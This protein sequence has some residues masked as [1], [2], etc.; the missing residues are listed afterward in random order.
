MGYLR[1]S[2]PGISFE[3]VKVGE[4]WAAT[5]LRAGG[6]SGSKP[7]QYVQVSVGGV[8]LD[9]YLEAARQI[10]EGPELADKD[11]MMTM[12]LSGDVDTALTES[13]ME[14]ARSEWRGIP[15]DET[16]GFAASV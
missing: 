10:V 1:G 16:S 3:E 12:T 6:A 4:G 7:G 2:A 15:W 8:I 5:R 9:V 14:Y 13:I 11:L